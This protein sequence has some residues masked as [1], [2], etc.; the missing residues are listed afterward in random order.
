M[1]LVEQKGAQGAR[2]VP[3][4]Q[5]VQNLEINRQEKQVELKE[6]SGAPATECEADHFALGQVFRNVLE[7]AIAACPDER[8]EI[9]IGVRDAILNERQPAVTVSIH[10]NGPGFIDDAQDQIFD[11]FFTTKTKGTG[12]GMSIAKRIV[13]AHGGKISASNGAHGGAQINITLPR[14]KR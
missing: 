13:E 6:L 2:G 14:S 3:D 1:R 5:T 12:L 7:N 10:D 9:E 4:S 8:G 11:P